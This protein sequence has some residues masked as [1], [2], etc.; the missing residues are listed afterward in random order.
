MK[1][2]L[3]DGF[4][5]LS[6]SFELYLVLNSPSIWISH[7][8]DI[9][10]ASVIGCGGD[11]KALCL[12]I[13]LFTMI[14]FLVPAPVQ[15]YLIG[16]FIATISGKVTSTVVSCFSESIHVQDK[17]IFQ[18]WPI[19]E[20]YYLMMIFQSTSVSVCHTSSK[21]FDLTRF[22]FVDGWWIENQS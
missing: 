2:N 12:M 18:H 14:I 21:I 15:L 1:K 9:F 19:W 20:N 10:L 7:Y 22:V 3:L 17:S 16:F 13:A 5:C 11:N 6:L 8:S 4:K